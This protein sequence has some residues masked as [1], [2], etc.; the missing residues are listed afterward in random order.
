VYYANDNAT[1]VLQLEVR[2]PADSGLNE[3]GL[4]IAPPEFFRRTSLVKNGSFETCSLGPPDYPPDFCD[5]S[6]NWENVPGEPPEG[7]M[8]IDGWVV[9]EGGSVDI[10]QT[11]WEA[12]HGDRSIDLF[13]GGPGPGVIK[14]D[15]D[16]LSPG[17][18]YRLD[19][20][21][22]GIPA[23]EDE[24]RMCVRIL[25]QGVEHA[26]QVFSFYK[27]DG[28]TLSHMKWK[29]LSLVFVAQN[30]TETIQF[31]GVIV[32][33][34]CSATTGATLDNVSLTELQ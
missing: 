29:H 10:G 18:Q 23:Q 6:F 17:K 34:N 8:N 31:E 19:F 33:E 26:S 1:S 30:T 4:D 5:G 13:G 14:Q 11:S 24:K 12:A 32:C 21:M 3:T 16:G 22:S 25:N 27:Q 9:L 20:Y 15:V 7:N 28:Q 2:G